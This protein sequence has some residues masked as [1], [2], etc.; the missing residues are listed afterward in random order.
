MM[1][2][3]RP[4]GFV[5]TLA[6]QQDEGGAGGGAAVSDNESRSR[7]GDVRQD[8]IVIG[9]SSG[10]VEAL[11]RLVRALPADLPATV[12]IVLHRPPRPDH[13]LPQILSRAGL[14]PATDAVDGER[15]YRGRIYIAPAD[16]HLLIERGVLRTVRG[17]K[18][19]HSRPAIDPLFRT[20]ALEFGPRVVGVILSGTLSDG[21]AGLWAIKRRGGVALVQDPDEAAS[22][23]MPRSAIA[24]VA[25]D[26]V[27]PVDEIPAVLVRLAGG[28]TRSGIE[29]APPGDNAPGRTVQEES[30]TAMSGIGPSEFERLP[31]IVE[32]DRAEQIN[33]ERHG[34]TSIFSCPECG[35]V[36]WQ[37]DAGPILQFRCHV[38]HAYTGEGLVTEQTDG[39][40]KALWYAIR[41]LI[42]QS[43]LLQQ[44]AERARDNGDSGSAARLE[45]EARVSGE[46]AERL[47]RI[48]E[49]EPD[50]GPPMGNDAA[51]K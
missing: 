28:A 6:R 5:P 20:A 49:R 35:G 40:E 44:L 31:G 25:V 30:V 43:L 47:R 34:R 50:L 46:H 24:G 26:C 7:R 2:I 15:P 48:A 9:A 38:G 17:P 51:P 3:V 32:Q 12:L 8:I 37:A 41:T 21:T 45:A 10:G 1:K 14:L 39:V 33:G 16:R 18:E 4:V 19:N 42:D 29:E 11:Q 36:L 13:L 23:G 22:P 27:L